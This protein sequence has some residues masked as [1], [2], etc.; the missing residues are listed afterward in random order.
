MNFGRK[1]NR[2]TGRDGFGGHAEFFAHIAFIIFLMGCV[3]VGPGA[4]F[5]N[6]GL[7][8]I[9]AVVWFMGGFMIPVLIVGW[10]GELPS[11]ILL[12]AGAVVMVGVFKEYYA[13]P[14]MEKVYC[15]QPQIDIV[16][17]AFAQE[18]YFTDHKKYIVTGDGS[19]LDKENFE[20]SPD[21]TIKLSGGVVKT[22]DGPVEYF[23]AHASHKGCDMDDD[24]KPDIFVWDSSKGGLQ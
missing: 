6:F 1:Y 16:N 17:L 13:D 5:D 10:M 20:K 21:V 14:Y 12:M 11:F 23:V 3:I 22:P 7:F 15:N 24:G 4:F 18:A 8:F 9:L 2:I 19:N